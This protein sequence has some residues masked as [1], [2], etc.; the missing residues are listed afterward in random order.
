M[1]M[2]EQLLLLKEHLHKMYRSNPF[3]DLLQISI[4][5]MEEGMAKLIMPIAT[6]H[7]NLFNVVHGGALATLADTAM[8]VAC[9][10][11]GKKIVTL[12]MNM[13]FI[14]AA[15]PQEVITA[16]ARVVHNGGSTL[17]AETDIVDSMSN[18]LLKAR[19]TFFVVGKF[20]PEND[21]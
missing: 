20:L 11:T 17:V 21:S 6:K 13:N 16:I 15:E 7:T 3:V 5:E 14:R 9:A 4:I 19:G 1:V 8:G 18:L 2:T 10:M 12:D